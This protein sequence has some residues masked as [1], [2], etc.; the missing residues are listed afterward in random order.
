MK[1]E[2]IHSS[3]I[4]SIGYSPIRKKLEVEFKSGDVYRYKSVPRNTYKHMMSSESKGRFLNEHI[5]Y[6][7]PY[8]KYEDKEGNKVR[9]NWHSLERKKKM[10]K[11]S[12]EYLVDK[13]FYKLAADLKPAKKTT[14]T[15]EDAKKVIKELGI[16]MSKVKWSLDDL[17]TGMNVELEHGTANKFTNIT[18]DALVLTTKIALA[19]L[20]EFPTYYDALAKMEAELKKKK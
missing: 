1:R 4:K 6:K 8:R 10:D 17:V 9:E 16:D 11:T 14:L 19:H 15:K 5:K 18:N 12:Y 13:Y 2:D 3:N 20:E 7:Y